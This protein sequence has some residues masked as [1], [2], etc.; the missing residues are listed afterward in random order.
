MSPIIRTKKKYVMIN[1]NFLHNEKLSLKAKGILT[2]LLSMPDSYKATPE[3]LAKI[4]KDGLKAIESGLREL[5]E[6]GYLQKY[7]VYK[8]KKIKEWEILVFEESLEDTEKIKFKTITENDL[9]LITYE[10]PRSKQNKKTN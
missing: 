8:N 9:E 5:K 10:I 4:N 3:Y 7:P 2:L 6:H 1:K